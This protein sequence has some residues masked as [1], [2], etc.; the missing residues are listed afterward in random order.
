MGLKVGEMF[1]NLGVNGSEKTVG[2]LQAT[3]KG[4]TGLKSM[5]LE[6]K[7]AIVATFYMIGKLVSETGRIG[8]GFLNFKA[9]TGVSTKQLQQYQYAL[10]QVGGSN[11]EMAQTFQT[12][13]TAMMNMMAG[14]GAPATLAMMMTTLRNNKVKIDPT[15]SFLYKDNPALLMQRLQQ[16]ANIEKNAAVRTMVL[17]GM[18]LSDTMAAALSR[19]AF[20]PEVMSRAPVISDSMFKSVARANAAW[21]ELGQHIQN[22]F[23]RFNAAHGQ[24][25]VRDMTKLVDS[26][27]RLIEALTKFSDKTGMWKSIASTVDITAASIDSM[28]GDK[29][30]SKKALENYAKFLV[31][32]TAG[33]PPSLNQPANTPAPVTV[34]Q[35]LQFADP[36]TDPGKVADVHKKA[37]RDAHSQ[38]PAIKGGR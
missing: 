11:E 38:Q 8:T 15:E 24:Q 30:F 22:A 27:I 1:V 16:Y 18:G 34:N 9:L 17:K 23:M 32:M 19:N 20:R 7:A 36:G 37:V 28:A 6:A 14:K 10:R 13:Q 25:L 31:V 35:T 21:I 29:K 2:A 26:S 3:S 33:V 5:S 12:L 4:M